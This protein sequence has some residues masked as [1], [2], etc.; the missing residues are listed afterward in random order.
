LIT[1]EF[2]EPLIRN[3]LAEVHKQS[4][5]SAKIELVVVSDGSSTGDALEKAKPLIHVRIHQ[6]AMSNTPCAIQTR[7]PQSFDNHCERE[8]VMM[9]SNEHVI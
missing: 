7:A 8:R 1:S 3:Y 5:E 6:C 4:E 2:A 9:P